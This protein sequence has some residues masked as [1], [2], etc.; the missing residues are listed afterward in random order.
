MLTQD[1]MTELRSMANIELL[2]AWK[3]ADDKGLKE[4]REAIDAIM[5]ERIDQQTHE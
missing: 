3:H 2:A 4:R 1:E 5:A